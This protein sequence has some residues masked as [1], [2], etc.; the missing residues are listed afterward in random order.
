MFSRNKFVRA[1][2]L[3]RLVLS[4]YF[5]VISNSLR[6]LSSAVLVKLHIVVDDKCI[7]IRVYTVDI[8]LEEK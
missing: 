7:H 8:I 6:H 2:S 4:K 1:I 5:G 3:D